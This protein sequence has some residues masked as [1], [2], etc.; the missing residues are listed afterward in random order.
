M[1]GIKEIARIENVKGFKRSRILYT[2]PE[3][4]IEMIFTFNQKYRLIPVIALDLNAC[5][6]VKGFLNG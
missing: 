5:H 4:L 1:L 3:L 6:Q 2:L